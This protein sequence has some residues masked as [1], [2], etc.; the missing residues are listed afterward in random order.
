[1]KKTKQLSQ[2]EL[3]DEK[4]KNTKAGSWCSCAC[5]YADSG[6]SSITDNGRANYSGGVAGYFSPGDPRL[7]PY[8]KY[9][10]E[11]YYWIDN[12]L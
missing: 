1:M 8:S 3:T 4:M 2:F 9:Y 6:G 10:D 5:A 11:E 12:I 7:H